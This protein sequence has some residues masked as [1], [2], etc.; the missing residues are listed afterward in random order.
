VIGGHGLVQLQE[1]GEVLCVGHDLVGGWGA[2]TM[3][4]KQ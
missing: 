3:K 2:A 1:A 4:E